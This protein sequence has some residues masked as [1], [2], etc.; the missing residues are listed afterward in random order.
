MHMSIKQKIVKEGLEVEKTSLEEIEEK[1]TAD[2]SDI[3]MAWEEKE[4][5]EPHNVELHDEYE[6]DQNQNYHW[7]M[8]E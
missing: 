1:W 3:G 8:W 6:V 2:A 7:K 5:E 4:K